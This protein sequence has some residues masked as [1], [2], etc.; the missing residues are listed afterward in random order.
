MRV[1]CDY[2]GKVYILRGDFKYLK[3]DL[4]KSCERS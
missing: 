3:G 1:G 4:V 2:L